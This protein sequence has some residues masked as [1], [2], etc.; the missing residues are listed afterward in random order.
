MHERVG[1]TNK[2]DTK[3]IA[4]DAPEQAQPEQEKDVMVIPHTP[5]YVQMAEAKSLEF[6][7]PKRWV[8]MEKMASTFINSGAVP[9]S[10]KNTAQMMMVFQAGYEAGLQPL[11]SL[12]A[13]YIV[14]GKITMYGDAVI[15]QIVRAGHL[16]VWG[17]CDDKK[18][19][20][21]ITRGDNGNKM[22]GK[23]TIE[24]AR[25]KGLT[26]YSNGNENAFW[27]KYPENML[28]YKA[29]GTIV[30]FIVPDALRGISVKE[31]IEADTEPAGSA[32]LAVAAQAIASAP[33][34]DKAG[35]NPDGVKTNRSSLQDVL[36]K[37]AE[38]TEAEIKGQ[39]SEAAE[40]TK[41][42]VD[43]AKRAN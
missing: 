19:E 24:Q 41:K 20:V 35:I 13:F 18:A 5:E 2:D 39:E 38:P 25:A 27:K 43:N 30:D 28:K 10:I 36:N 23:F 7:N 3:D 32:P 16:V 11:E 40:K 12:N 33:A 37:P 22:T 42:D 17:K 14:N 29:L 26:T 4:A 9:E 1:M 6:M 15:S 34:A 8:V 21:T 31:V